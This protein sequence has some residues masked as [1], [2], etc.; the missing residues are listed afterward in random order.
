M[1][2]FIKPSPEVSWY[3][4]TKSGHKKKVGRAHGCTLKVGNLMI[5]SFMNNRKECALFDFVV[6]G[7]SSRSS[8]SRNNHA[9]SLIAGVYVS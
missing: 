9:M 8:C 5:R 6:V 1:V 3:S 7:V 2:L 4:V